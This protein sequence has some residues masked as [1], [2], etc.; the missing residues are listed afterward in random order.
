MSKTCQPFLDPLS[1]VCPDCVFF[2]PPKPRDQTRERGRARGFPALR[3]LQ[4]PL[5]PGKE[6]QGA[7]LPPQEDLPRHRVLEAWVKD[8]KE[9]KESGAKP[10]A[11]G[12][13]TQGGAR[14]DRSGEGAIRFAPTLGKPSATSQVSDFPVSVG[15]KN[16]T[17]TRAGLTQLF[18][19]GEREEKF[20]RGRRKGGKKQSCRH[21]GCFHA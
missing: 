14:E 16:P 10:G 12:G 3:N 19:S 15:K 2:G 4:A 7:A 11:E 6:D 9:G 5:I 8:P 13:E 17:P 18:I 1:P 21:V 20:W